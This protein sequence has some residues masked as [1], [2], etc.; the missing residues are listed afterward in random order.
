MKLSIVR[1]IIVST[2]LFLATVTLIEAKT[3]WDTPTPTTSESAG[4]AVEPPKAPNNGSER[5][6]FENSSPAYA[7][8]PTA[9]NPQKEFPVPEGFW[10]LVGLAVT[11]YAIDV[12]RRHKK[13][14]R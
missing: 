2:I 8:P 7:P 11:Y 9:G 10:I 4:W 14:E 5:A 12:F 3:Q 13:G 1:N 6:P